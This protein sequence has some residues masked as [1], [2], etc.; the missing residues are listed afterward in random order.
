[1]RLVLSM[2]KNFLKKKQKHSYVFNV[3]I[4]HVYWD[5]LLKKEKNSRKNKSLITFIVTWANKT[6][7]VV[8]PSKYLAT[9]F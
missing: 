2:E 5:T 7:I 9:V 4:S 6:Y 3:V 8:N 1:M